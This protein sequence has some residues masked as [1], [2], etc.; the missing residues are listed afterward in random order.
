MSIR[1]TD[2]LPGLVTCKF[3]DLTCYRKRKITK[4]GMKCKVNLKHAGMDL[5]FSSN[6]CDVLTKGF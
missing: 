5:S 6:A 4:I 2:M 1:G 3:K